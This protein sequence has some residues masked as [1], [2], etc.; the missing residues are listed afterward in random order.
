MLALTA[1]LVV[2]MPHA[3][4]AQLFGERSPV[5][6]AKDVKAPLL[7][8]MGAEDKR[9]PAKQGEEMIEALKKAG[10]NPRYTEYPDRGHAV[11]EPN[12]YPEVLDWMFAQH[13]QQKDLK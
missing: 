7:I 6:F 5:T 4:S 9:V 13:K 8:V 3:A 1:L 10:G 11:G 2:S 12:L